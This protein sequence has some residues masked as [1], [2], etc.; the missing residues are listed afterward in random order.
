MYKNLLQQHAQKEN[1]GFPVYTSEAEGPPHARRFKSKVSVN[2]KS[3][4]TSEFFTT[5]KE[6]EQTA[7]RI[8]CQALSVGV[9]QE[10]GSLILD[11]KN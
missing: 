9:I 6:A 3:Y 11:F 8:A 5:L 4:E 10:A 2:G 1:I 7:A